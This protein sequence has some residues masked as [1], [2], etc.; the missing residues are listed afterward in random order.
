MGCKREGI[1]TLS[2]CTLGE[3]LK[4]PHPPSRRIA[5]LKQ[6]DLAW[7]KRGSS[8]SNALFLL[9]GTVESTTPPSALRFGVVVKKKLGNSVLRNR[10]KRRIRHVFFQSKP[11]AT[12]V[13]CFVIV[14]S[15]EVATEDFAKLSQALVSLLK[16]LASHGKT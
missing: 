14:K 5:V 4:Q 9:R 6:G 8:F 3:D 12:S 1:K 11:L 16:R 13:S 7:K 15:A 2:S 10:I